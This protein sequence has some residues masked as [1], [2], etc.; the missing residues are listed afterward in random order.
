MDRQE[1]LTYIII[2]FILYIC[3]QIY[4]ESD[5][6]NFNVLFLKLMVINIVFVNEL[7]HKKQLIY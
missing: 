7:F 2:G 1:I 6:F 5:T 4:R 3:L